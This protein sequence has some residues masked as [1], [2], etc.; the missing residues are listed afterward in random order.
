MR[1]GYPAVDAHLVIL[2]VID[3]FQAERL[4]QQGFAAPGRVAEDVLAQGGQSRA[5]ISSAIARLRWGV[6]VV[7]DHHE[8]A[9]GLLVR[10]VQEPGVVRLGEALRRSLP[11]LRPVRAR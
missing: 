2:L 11:C 8:R 6:Q 5:A 10:G 7:P 1:R 9:A 3:Q 4:E